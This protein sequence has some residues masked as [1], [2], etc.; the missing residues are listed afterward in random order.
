MNK[1]SR[2]VAIDKFTRRNS[3]WSTLPRENGE[4]VQ[5]LQYEIGQYYKPHFDFFD[6]AIYEA[7]L[8][9]GG[10]RVASVLCFLND[11]EEGGE[12]LFP[13]VN[14]A[15]KPK[16]GSAILWYNTYLNGTLDRNA[17]HGGN[18]VIKGIKYVAV[19]WLREFEIK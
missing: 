4:D 5:I 12:T 1:R 6:P 8:R 3:L 10:Q 9:N 14:L 13:A 17:L 18:P 15:V 7:Y 16:K 19:Q 11:V 2:E